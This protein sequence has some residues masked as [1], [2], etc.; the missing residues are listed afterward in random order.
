MYSTAW[1]NMVPIIDGNSEIVANVRSKSLLFDM[2][3][4]RQES[5]HKLDFLFRK[6]LFSIIRA[7]NFLSY[8]LI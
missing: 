3:L 2:F 6:D 1:E 7:Q 8:L 4:I 5:S